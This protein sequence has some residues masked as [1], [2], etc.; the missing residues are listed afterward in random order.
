MSCAEHLWL[1]HPRFCTRPSTSQCSSGNACPCAAEAVRLLEK[2][3]CPSSLRSLEGRTPVH[4]AA[5]QVRL[6]TGGR[7]RAGLCSWEIS[8]WAEVCGILV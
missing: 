3:Q 2:L 1:M 8:V 5:E 4:V 6:G 7:G